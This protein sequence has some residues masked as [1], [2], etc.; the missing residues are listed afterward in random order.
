MKELLE[1]A[2][3]P[4]DDVVFF[5]RTNYPLNIFEPRY[6]RMVRDSLS[7]GL[8]IALSNQDPT[9]PEGAALMSGRPPRR[10]LVVGYGRTHVVHTRGD[11]TMVIVLQGQGKA[12]LLEVVQEKPY[13][14]CQ[15]ERI[16]ERESIEDEQRFALNRLERL[17]ERW[18]DEN[19]PDA[20]QRESLRRSLVTPQSRLETLAMCRVPDADV[21]QAILEIDDLNERV[22]FM[23]FLF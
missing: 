22:R 6:V 1:L 8:P 2:V 15:A 14:I 4:L 12:R 18:M 3:F 10:G 13:L 5:P 16:D 23:K 11:G 20:E 9:D 21:R 19:V 17:L 7:A